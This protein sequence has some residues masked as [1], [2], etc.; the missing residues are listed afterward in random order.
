MLHKIHTCNPPDNVQQLFT[1]LNQIHSYASRSAER[2][3][4]L[5]QA[6]SRQNG[7]LCLNNPAPKIWAIWIPPFMSFP[8][9]NS[10]KGTEIL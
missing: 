8:R 4:F 6:A 7:K 2:E 3:A 1:P 9:L 5:W 10:K